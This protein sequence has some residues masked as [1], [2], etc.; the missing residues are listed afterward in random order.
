MKEEEGNGEMGERKFHSP[1][2]RNF[3][4]TREVFR[5]KFV[6]RE[7]DQC[8]GIQK[9]EMKKKKQ[10]SCAKAHRHACAHKRD[11]DEKRVKEKRKS[12]EDTKEERSLTNGTFMRPW[13]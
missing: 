9:K 13:C 7:R 12:G 2:K 3:V 11:R 1:S 6:S 4:C 10:R 8:E 5:E